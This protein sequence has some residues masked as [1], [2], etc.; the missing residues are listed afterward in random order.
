MSVKI[1]HDT[2]RKFT[3][4]A[5]SRHRE[6]DGGERKHEHDLRGELLSWRYFMDL[7]LPILPFQKVYKHVHFYGGMGYDARRQYRIRNLFFQ[8]KKKEEKEKPPLTNFSY[9]TSSSINNIKKEVNKYY[10][11]T[12]RLRTILP[13]HLPNMIYL[14]EGSEINI[15]HESGI[16][17][18]SFT[19]NTHPRSLV[20][21]W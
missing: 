21:T 11:N 9:F 20:N 6:E 12:H 16:P 8:T 4:S 17:D 18:F 5:V 15:K 1:T 14:Q 7:S 19:S 10:I 2:R 13:N 3:G